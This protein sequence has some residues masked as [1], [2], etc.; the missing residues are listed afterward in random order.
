MNE[1]GTPFRRHL[2][3]CYIQWQFRAIYREDYNEKTYDI[4]LTK[5]VLIN[6]EGTKIRIRRPNR[7]VVPRLAKYNEQETVADNFA[8]VEERVYDLLNADVFLL[9]LEVPVRIRWL[10]RFPIAIKLKEPGQRGG[11]LIVE[12]NKDDALFVAK[13]GA[14]LFFF[15]RCDRAKEEIFWQFVSASGKVPFPFTIPT[16]T[17]TQDMSVINAMVTR[18]GGDVLVDPIWKKI[19][20]EKVA[21]KISQIKRPYYLQDIKLTDLDMG[22]ALPTLSNVSERVKVDKLGTWFTMDMELKG[23]IRSTIVAHVDLMKF[24]DPEEAKVSR[25]VVLIGQFK[26][27]A[28][29]KLRFIK[30]CTGEEGRIDEEIE[31]LRGT[32]NEC[33][34]NG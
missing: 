6:F 15:A 33:Q 21:Q 23:P 32:N 8:W 26:S 2:S 1:Q 3:V 31:S 16:V 30:T 17:P 19:I 27:R 12:S 5:T 28:F 11:N 18:I 29:L 4:K 9:P 34:K 22:T 10:S 13:D 7:R 25:K 14:T 20:F 24:R